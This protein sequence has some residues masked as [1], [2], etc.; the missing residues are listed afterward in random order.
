MARATADIGL[1]T[2]ISTT[3][4]TPFHAARLLAS[5]DHIS[6]GRAGW[7][8]VT[9]MFDQEAR[10]HGLEAMPDHASRYE[11]ADEFV[12]VALALWDSWSEDALILD[13]SGRFADANRISRIDHDGKHFRVDGPL[14]VPRSPQGRPVLFQAGASEQG[15]D[16][17]ARRAEAIYSVAYDLPSAQAYYADVKSR[18]ERAGRDSNSVAVM[19]G[20]VTYVAAPSPR[21]GRRR[22]NSISC[23]PPNSRYA[24]SRCSPD[25]IARTGISTGPCPRCLHSKRSP[26]RRELRHYFADRR[27]GRTDC[28]GTPRDARCGW[29]SRNDDRNTGVDCRRDGILV[30]RPRCRRFQ[31]DAADYPQGLEDFVDHVIPVLQARGLFRREYEGATLRENLT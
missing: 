1:V 17:A 24:N 21:P 20:L 13:R 6:G 23:C 30:E 12:E 15:R 22:P 19:P 2:T 11:R 18:I 5:L 28:A 31:S 8:V 9:S 29:W 3:F 16:L 14:T 26:G 7:N 10:N 4:Y 25:R 27:E